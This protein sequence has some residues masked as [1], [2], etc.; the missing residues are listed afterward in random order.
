MKKKVSE[1]GRTHPYSQGGINKFFV[2]EYFWPLVPISP[3]SRLD[4]IG[5]L[6]GVISGVPMNSL[7]W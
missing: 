1:E 2:H 5:K 3:Q 6:I 4:W 7:V